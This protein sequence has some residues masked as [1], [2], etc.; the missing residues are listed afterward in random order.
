MLIAS[1]TKKLRL[2]PSDLSVR[3]QRLWI[4]FAIKSDTKTAPGWG[5]GG[6][7]LERE[8][9]THTRSNRCNATRPLSDVICVKGRRGRGGEGWGGREGERKGGRK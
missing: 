2:L 4:C 9:G 1:K 8:E 7:D 3:R 6:S 5:V